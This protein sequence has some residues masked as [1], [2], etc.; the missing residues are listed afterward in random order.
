[1]ISSELLTFK[2]MCILSRLLFLCLRM[3]PVPSSSIPACVVKPLYFQNN[4]LLNKIHYIHEINTL[5]IIILAVQQ[6]LYMYVSTAAPF[7]FIHKDV[8]CD[9]NILCLFSSSKANYHDR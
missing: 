9:I 6:K 4:S 1:M 3:W 8:L 5:S 7:S 2:I